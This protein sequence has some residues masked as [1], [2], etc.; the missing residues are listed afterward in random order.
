M[1]KVPTFNKYIDAYSYWSI[2]LFLMFFLM[3]CL[4][5]EMLEKK[6][7]TEFPNQKNGIQVAMIAIAVIT[8]FFEILRAIINMYS[9]FKEVKP[10]LFRQRSLLQVP[11]DDDSKQELLKTPPRNSGL[12][13]RPNLHVLKKLNRI[14]RKKRKTVKS[15]SNFVKY[16]FKKEPAGR[17]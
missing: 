15:K 10:F 5:L 3:G 6:N 13:Q 12:F 7:S 14:S 9:T 8:L 1:N 17:K 11:S 4:T 2:E 16:N